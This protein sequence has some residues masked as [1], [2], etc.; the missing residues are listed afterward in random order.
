VVAGDA[1]HLVTMFAKPFEELARLAELLGPGALGEIAADD[2]EVRLEAVDLL[3]DSF[4]EALVMRAEVE[5]GKMDDT[6]H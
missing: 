1:K 5:V 4:H 2:D 3:A 6:S